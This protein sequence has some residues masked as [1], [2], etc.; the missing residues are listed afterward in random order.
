ML[1]PEQ[2]MR[3]GEEKKR[4]NTKTPR[5]MVVIVFVGYFAL[6]Q[7]RQMY[8]TQALMSRIKKNPLFHSPFRLSFMNPPNLGR[9]GFVP[10]ILEESAARNRAVNKGDWA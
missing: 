8:L 5:A 4:E 2:K 9:A 6:R 10:Q 3:W 1:S 7:G